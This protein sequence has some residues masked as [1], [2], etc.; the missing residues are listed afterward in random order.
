MKIRNEETQ[1][2]N[3]TTQP[4]PH[5]PT[6]NTQGVLLEFSEFKRHGVDYIVPTDDEVSANGFFTV[7]STGCSLCPEG[8]TSQ[9]PGLPLWA[10]LGTSAKKVSTAKRLRQKEAAKEGRYPSTFVYWAGWVFCG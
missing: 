10:T 6:S 1:T 4:T 5:N 3:R 7:S 8:A 2:D 9:S